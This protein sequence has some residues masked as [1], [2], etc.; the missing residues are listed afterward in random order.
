M[1][2]HAQASTSP[3]GFHYTLPPPQHALSGDGSTPSW[4]GPVAVIGIGGVLLWLLVRGLGARQKMYQSVADKE[5]SSGVL[6]LQAGEAAIG[7]GSMWAGE[8]LGR[9]YRKNPRRKR[10]RR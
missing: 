7:L 1:S 9:H 4:V 2:Y 10:R 3:L 5:G 6:K 8:A